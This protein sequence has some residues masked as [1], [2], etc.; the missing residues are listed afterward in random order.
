MKPIIL[1]KAGFDIDKVDLNLQSIE[2]KCPG[3]FI[4]SKNDSLIPFSQIDQIFNRFK[5][6]KEMFFIDET[7]NESR[8]LSVI[9]KIFK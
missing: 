3:I 9:R 4:A 6:E 8:N 2:C 1:E 7:H 5:N